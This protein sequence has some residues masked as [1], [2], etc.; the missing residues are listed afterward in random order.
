VPL[1]DFIA[2]VEKDGFRI[3]PISNAHISAY[4]LLPIIPGHKDFFD[5]FLIVTA[6]EEKMN[7]ITAD[8]KFNSYSHLVNLI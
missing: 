2:Q 5:R 8:E 3:L 6:I 1:S 7:L 4:P